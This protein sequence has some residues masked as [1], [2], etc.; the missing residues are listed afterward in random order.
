MI[1]PLQEVVRKAIDPTFHYDG[2]M[3]YESPR[4]TRDCE[5]TL[6]A[7]TTAITGRY[8]VAAQQRS[9][10]NILDIALQDGDTPGMLV[11]PETQA[12]II[13]TGSPSIVVRPVFEKSSTVTGG[14]AEIQ[15]FAHGCT[16][17]DE[18]VPVAYHRLVFANA[19]IPMSRSFNGTF[20]RRTVHI[21]DHGAVNGQAFAVVA[22]DGDSLNETE[23]RALWYAMNF[24]CGRKTSQYLTEGYDEHGN[25]VVRRFR[26]GYGPKPEALEPFN[27][28][29]F[30]PTDFVNIFV[31][32]FYEAL[33]AGFPIDVML[34][35]FFDGIDAILDFHLQSLI[36]AIHAAIESWHKLSPPKE[37]PD[38]VKWLE[39]NKKAILDALKPL[40]ASA[41]TFVKDA[42]VS[43]VRYSD[44]YGTGKRERRFLAGWDLSPLGTPEKGGLA[45]RDQLVHD[46]HFCVRFEDLSVPEQQKRVDFIRPLLNLN[47]RILCR[48][49]GYTGLFIDQCDLKSVIK[50]S[51]TAMFPLPSPPYVAST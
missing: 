39:N 27:V 50:M 4:M 7:S 22:H 44:K 34:E 30:P 12:E 17:G 21:G 2:P 25:L 5:G 11:T 24:L 20:N 14:T 23:W 16:V 8:E 48:A 31:Q 51:G 18:T 29:C 46:G 19:P 32:G 28:Y 13:C 1:A 37:L 43:G 41:P 15:Y 36:L 49:V 38:G 26:P 9:M 3:H 47:I 42:V 10:L 40:L 35:H 6:D 45:L 33:R